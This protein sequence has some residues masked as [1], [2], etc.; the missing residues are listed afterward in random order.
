MTCCNYQ[1]ADHGVVPVKDV[2]S[3]VPSHQS[4]NITPSSSRAVII[5]D[6]SEIPHIAVKLAENVSCSHSNLAQHSHE[7]CNSKIES[8]S[9]T[10][11]NEADQTDHEVTGKVWNSPD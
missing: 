4:C 9:N 2:E 3:S 8:H 7:S 11:T 6:H 5:V 1:R 10:R